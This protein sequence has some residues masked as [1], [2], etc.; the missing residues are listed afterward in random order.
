M[1]CTYILISGIHAPSGIFLDFERA[2]SLISQKKKKKEL[3]SA[4]YPLVCSVNNWSLLF[5]QLGPLQF[6]TNWTIKPTGS[7]SFCEFILFHRRWIDGSQ[8]HEILYMWTADEKLQWMQVIHQIPL[9]LRTQLFGAYLKIGRDKEVF[10]FNS[11]VHFPS[12]RK[13]YSN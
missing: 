1:W 13:F 9:H 10:S 5:E 11:T 6:S 4:G 3:L 8:I 2:F 7:W 12:V